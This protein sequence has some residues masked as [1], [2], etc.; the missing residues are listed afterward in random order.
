M[1]R[2]E[3]G[4]SEGVGLFAKKETMRQVKNQQTTSFYRLCHF[5]AVLMRFDRVDA[6]GCQLSRFAA[7]V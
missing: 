6:S 3:E 2:K 7:F 5:H 4:R 1:E